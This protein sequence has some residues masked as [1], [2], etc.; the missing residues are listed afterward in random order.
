MQNAA[1]C[2]F[3]QCKIS[4]TFKKDYI[5]IWMFYSKKIKLKRNLQLKSHAVFNPTFDKWCDNRYG[6]RPGHGKN[7]YEGGCICN[8]NLFVYMIMYSTTSQV[9]SE[10]FTIWFIYGV[11]FGAHKD[12]YL[13][14]LLNLVLFLKHFPIFYLLPI[15][16]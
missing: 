13:K 3:I 7:I 9:S 1:I 15:L 2:F 6:P 4:Y 5:S 12:R 11:L 8:F 10:I 16:L 14:K